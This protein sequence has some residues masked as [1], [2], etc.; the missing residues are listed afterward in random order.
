MGTSIDYTGGRGGA[1]T[2][3]KRAASSFARHGGSDRAGRVLARHV[4]TLGGAA[5]AAAGATAGARAARLL[6][7]LLAGGIPSTGEPAGL[8]FAA[9]GLGDL[10]G[11]DRSDVLDALVEAIAGDG[12][13]LEAQAARAAVLD[14]L[15]ELVLDESLDLADPRLDAEGVRALLAQF[16]AF[17]LYNRA[18]AIIEE[19][20]NRLNDPALAAR[21]DNE[22]RAVIRGIVDLQLVDL[23]PLAVD[24]SSPAG[25]VEVDRLLQTIY[26]MI[27]AMEE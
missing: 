8:D 3:Y 18:A 19:R 24:W 6:G 5:G 15:G 1:W 27:E 25:E 14:V 7:A 22:I 17:Y 10:V 9:V 21:R 11:A 16:L 4:A 12:A 23:D 13:S 26:T 2:P 20:L